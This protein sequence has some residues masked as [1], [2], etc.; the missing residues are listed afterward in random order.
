MTGVGGQWRSISGAS[1][2]SVLPLAVAAQTMTFSPSSRRGMAAICTSVKLPWRSKNA[3][4]ARGSR[5]FS[6][7]R[8]ASWIIALRPR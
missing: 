2:A 4:Q 7:S 6:A 1:A 3:G 5:A 8:S